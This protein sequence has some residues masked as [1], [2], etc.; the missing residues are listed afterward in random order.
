MLLTSIC[1]QSQHFLPDIDE[2]NS[3]N[4]GCEQNCHNSY[5][6]YKCTCDDGFKLSDNKHDCI[7]KYHPCL[8]QYPL[9]LV[10]WDW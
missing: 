8:F 1:N 10:Q 2:C 7:R 6:S 5:G 9:C 4:G 3:A